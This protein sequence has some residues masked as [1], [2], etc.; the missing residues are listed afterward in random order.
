MYST[1]TW[2]HLNLN[3]SNISWLETLSEDSKLLESNKMTD[4]II[5][6]SIGTY[7]HDTKK[8][9]PCELKSFN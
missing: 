4:K 1:M 7:T 6:D 3:K 2:I 9:H 8:R 5:F